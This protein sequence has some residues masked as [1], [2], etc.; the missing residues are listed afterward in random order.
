MLIAPSEP[1][2]LKAIGRSSQK[3]ER[4]GADILFPAQG[5]LVGIQRKTI[6]DLLAS[7]RDG[8]LQREMAQ[9]SRLGLAVLIVEGRPRWT[10]DGQLISTS[11][12]F[13]P[14]W[15]RS[16]HR[17]LLWSVQ[18]KGV[19]VTHTD[20]LADTI[21]TV[22]DLAGWSRKRAHQ[23]LNRRPKPSSTWGKA[24]HRDFALHLLQSFDGIGPI[25]AEAIL[26]HFGGVPL[27]WLATERQ[28]MQVPGVGKTR[29]KRLAEALELP[30]GQVASA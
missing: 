4:F 11:A 28:L 29:A 17:G 5:R 27:M 2:A 16:Q 21:D 24:G 18:A 26:D 22:R 30:A 12:G 20:D 9:M 23:S 7:V 13:G 14:Q 15:S 25:Q 19:S 1:P 6:A 8:R 3:P 10:L